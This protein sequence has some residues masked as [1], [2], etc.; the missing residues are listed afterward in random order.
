MSPYLHTC[1]YVSMRLVAFQLN[2]HAELGQMKSHF[3][4][5]T[6][7]LFPHQFPEF[8]DCL[9]KFDFD[10]LLGRS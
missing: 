5:R 1:T 10:L 2:I 7:V 6:R 4:G 8:A 3:H 9:T